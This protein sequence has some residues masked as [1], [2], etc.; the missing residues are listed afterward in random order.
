MNKLTHFISQYKFPIFFGLILLVYLINMFIDIMDVDASQYALI[1]MEMSITKSFLQVFQQGKDYLDK[2][3]MLF[4]LTSLS[5]LTFGISNFTYKLPSILVLI[6]GIYGLY[7]FT[8]LYYPK[9]TAILASLILASG[10]AVF[11]ITNDV[12]T[13]TILLGFVIISVWQFS[14]YLKYEKWINLVWA[15]LATG[16]AM[17]TKGPIALLIPVAAFSTDFIL[18]RKFKLFF[19]PQWI[20]ALIIMAVSLIPMSYGLYMQ[21]DLHP[22][23]YVYEIQGPSGLR[24]FYWTQSFGR[25]TGESTWNN[26][27]GYFFFFHSIIWDFQPWI[28]LFI[29]ALI[30][31][32]RK[33]IISKFKSPDT[34]EYITFGG[35][36]LIF[37]AFSASKY[38]LP[39]YVFVLYPFAAVLTADFITNLA[40]KTINR[41]SKIQFGIM[42]LFWAAILMVYFF[43]FKTQNLVLPLLLIVAYILNWIFFIRLKSGFD[44]LIITTLISIISFNA[45]MGAH[46]Y[47]NLL[48]YQAT[49][50]AGKYA[51][52]YIKPYENFYNANNSSFSL[53]FYAQNI[54]KSIA[55]S[56]I[57]KLKAGSLVFMNESNLLSLYNQNVKF[58]IKSSFPSF[59]VSML[60]PEFLFLKTRYK[61]V[62]KVYIIQIL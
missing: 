34:D 45:M 49:S 25:I 7:K 61:V 23:K 32:I 57:E 50:Q 55:I 56:D 19:K 27:A 9:Q 6:V 35:F 47:P 43:I 33:I 28:F 3:P 48:K 26:H 1:S 24:F 13:D 29:P 14:V 62:K 53:D 46:F 38:K 52:T 51:R 21:F 58:I 4:W 59:K 40:T 37:L 36:V 12:R 42:Q 15:A 11:L 5:F 10:Q 18:K 2:P 30:L 44:K 17:M 22:E 39:H 16:F 20:I 31:K 60:K 54:N 8:R 41:I